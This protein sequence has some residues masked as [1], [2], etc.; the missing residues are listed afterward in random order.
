MKVLLF[1]NP[2]TVDEE[3][4]KRDLS[5]L[6]A[7]RRERALEYRFPIDRVLCAKAYL[8][9][10]EGLRQAYGVREDP[11]FV[12]R[13]NGKPY[14]RDHPDIYFNL[15]HCRKGVL[16]AIDEA[17]V[18][19][20]I[21]EIPAAVDEA[22]CGICF[23]AEE[24][25]RIMNA[26]DP[27]AEFTRLWTMKEAYLKYTGEGITDDLPDIFSHRDI[28]KVRFQVHEEADGVIYTLCRGR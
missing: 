22:L 3:Q 20:D 21:E 15:S 2:Q 13:E 16:C 7:W 9:L 11:V 17:E 4:L 10:K 19:C 12:C 24:R 27:A 25:R 1:Q 18:G 6:P 28:R 23:Q 26:A 14:L 8:L 5:L